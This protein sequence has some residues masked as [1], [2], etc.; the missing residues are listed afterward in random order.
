MRDLLRAALVGEPS[1]EASF[2]AI[3]GAKNRAGAR[4]A[5]LR[6]WFDHEMGAQTTDHGGHADC[7]TTSP[8]AGLPFHDP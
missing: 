6:R 7:S 5:R 1:H 4:V 2:Q 8:N 3:A